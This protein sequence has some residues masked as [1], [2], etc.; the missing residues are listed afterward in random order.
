MDIEELIKRANEV[1]YTELPNQSRD[2]LRA[3]EVLTKIF[4]AYPTKFFESK[5][6]KNLL[7]DERLEVSRIGH[8]LYGMKAKNECIE[9]KK[10][11]YGSIYMS[12]LLSKINC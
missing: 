11:T 8:V 5:D 6:L 2:N 3:K 9:P 7:M 1:G 12:R 4:N 10:G